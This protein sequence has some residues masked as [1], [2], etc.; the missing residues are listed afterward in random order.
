MGPS[1]SCS[2]RSC[3]SVWMLPNCLLNSLSDRK[4]L[5]RMKCSSDHS[6]SVL[7]WIGVPVSSVRCSCSCQ[8]TNTQATFSARFRIPWSEP[9]HEANNTE[10]RHENHWMER[11][12]RSVRSAVNSFDC[13]FFNLH[14]HDIDIDI[15]TPTSNERRQTRACPTTESSAAKQGSLTGELRRPRGTSSQSSTGTRAVSMNETATKGG[16]SQQH[17]TVQ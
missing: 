17:R 16:V 6:S 14:T 13:G 5:G 4:S 11:T 10:K 3:S 15:E 9:T 8:E 2:S 7:F 1:W 12:T